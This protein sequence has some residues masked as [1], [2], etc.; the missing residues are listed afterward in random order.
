MRKTREQKRDIFIA[1]NVGIFDDLDDFKKRKDE[2]RPSPLFDEFKKIDLRD[3]LSHHLSLVVGEPGYGKT[4]LLRKIVKIAASQK[5]EAIFIELKG[6]TRGDTI[7]RIISRQSKQPD[8][9]KTEKF[10][11]TNSNSII[12]CLD[13][14]DEIRQDIFSEAVERIKEFLNE[15]KNISLLL[16]CRLNYYQKF[17]VFEGKKFKIIKLYPF[18]LKDTREYLEKSDI[19]EDTIELIFKKFRFQNRQLV[20]QTPRYLSLLVE[21][22]RSNPAID[23]SQINRVVL[24]EYFIYKKLEKEDRILG[25]QERGFMKR[26]LEKLAL[27]MEI[28]QANEISKDELMTFFDDTKSNLILSLLTQIPIETFYD[29]SLIKDNIQTISFE[30]PEFQEYLASKELLRLRK[31]EKALYDIVVDKELQEIHPSWFNTLGFLLEQKPDLLDKILNF[32]FKKT[33]LI[34]DD[35]YSRLLLKVNCEEMDEETRRAI[36]KEILTYYQEMEGLWLDWDIAEGLSYFYNNALSDFLKSWIDGRKNKRRLFVKRGNIALIVHFLLKNKNLSG[37]DQQYWKTKLI[38]FANDKD[39]NG[40]LQRHALYALGEFKDPLLIKKVESTW[41]HKDEFVKRAFLRFCYKTDPN[42]ALSVKYFVEGTKQDFLEA[43]YGIW[44]I[45]N[46]EGIKKLLESFKNDIL[47]FQHFLEKESIFRDKDHRIVQNVKVILDDEIAKLV[48]DVLIKGL[49]SKLS[50]RAEDS[51][52]IKSLTLLLKERDSNFLFKLISRI[53]KSKKLKTRIFSFQNIFA[54]ILEKNQVKKFISELSK[55]QPDKRLALWV[56]QRIKFS[57]RKDGEEI[58]EEGRRYLKKEYK[59]SEEFARKE[60]LQQP[61]SG[62]ERIYKEFQL[63][64]EPEKGKYDPG[65]FR[66]YIN[67]EKILREKITEVEKKRII[68]LMTGSIFEKFDP[69]D[70]YKIFKRNRRGCN[71][72]S[73]NWHAWNPVFG[74]CIRLA[75][76]LG[77]DVSKYRQRIINFIPFADYEEREAILK[78]VTNIKARELKPILDIYKSNP[79]LKLF[80]PESFIEVVVKNNLV[81][82]VS[83]LKEFVKEETLSIYGRKE[84]LK[85]I[86]SLKPDKSFLEEIFKKYEK[87]KNEAFELSETA[88]QLLIEK[89]KDREAIDWRF[90]QLKERIFEF[91]ESRGV[92]WVSPQEDELYEK[93]FAAPLMVLKEAFYVNKFLDLLAFSFKKIEENKL[94]WSYVQYLWE[95]VFQYFDNL[96]YTRSYEPIKQ[97]E[98]FLQ[99]KLNS[100]YSN[101]FKGTLKRLKRSYIV[102]IGK[103][104]N[105]TDAIKAFNEIKSKQYLSIST[106]EEIFDHI[107]KIID[108]DLKNWIE[109]EGG[110]K[111]IRDK[112]ERKIQPTIQL[113]LENKFLKRGFDFQIYREPQLLDSKRVDFLINYG[114]IGQILLELKLSSHPDLQGENLRKRKSFK[115]LQQYMEGFGVNYGILLIINDAKVDD[116]GLNKIKDS[117]SKIKGLETMKLNLYRNGDNINNRRGPQT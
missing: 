64:L 90:T 10:N 77:L 67:N 116:D 50:Y 111:I 95:I 102:Y 49:E 32:G 40:V 73:F 3:L 89:Y 114:F 68:N 27:I 96:K 5:K 79:D 71:I 41:K 42:C 38:K 52:F 65:V 30:N 115:S 110:G 36:F 61:E 14:L 2:Y 51:N 1:P 106:P 74:D 92:H 105:I 18:S 99:D 100:D 86:E 54:S 20:I 17:P 93:K 15:Y 69:K 28:Y 85:A 46:R 21:Y 84:A 34:I 70:G 22:I 91:E 81:E 37:D 88:N 76:L 72:I 83:V 80:R 97:L 98:D 112:S 62:E 66:F 117:Y 63:R 23:I 29:K 58:Y 104:N 6:F 107:K 57:G 9:I 12:I 24:F 103:P 7:A 16:S 47:F 60:K 108:E 8:A 87:S 43:R 31:L 109:N 33:R 113:A 25:K 101:W 78:L 82:G 39:E 26:V 44:E 19:P 45:T 59:E 94:Y 56:L 13:G 35:E 55:I 75:S 11:L 4:Y 53:K 48:S